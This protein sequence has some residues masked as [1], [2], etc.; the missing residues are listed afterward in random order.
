MRGNSEARA[1]QLLAVLDGLSDPVDNRGLSR[2]Q[3]VTA[4][5]AAAGEARRP[6]LPRIFTF[7]AHM[8]RW[9][10]ATGWLLDVCELNGMHS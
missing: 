3:P 5:A 6:W 10:G 9:G 2:S 7:Y 1:A 8:G 4:A